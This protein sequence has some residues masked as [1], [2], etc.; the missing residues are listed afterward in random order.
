[1]E[2]IAP[3][4]PAQLFQAMCSSKA[5]QNILPSDDESDE[6]AVDKTLLGALAECYHAATCWETRR[7]ILPIIADKVSFRK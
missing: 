4:S 2:D 5:I 7:Q 6:V 1:M 3:R